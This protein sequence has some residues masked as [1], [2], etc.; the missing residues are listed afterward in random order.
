MNGISAS[1]GG[2]ERVEAEHRRCRGTSTTA[3]QGS[4]WAA[5][6][7]WPGSDGRAGSAAGPASRRRAVIRGVI[8]PPPFDQLEERALDVGLAGAPQ[9]AVRGVVG[10]QPCPRASAAAGRTV[11][12]V[13]HVAAHDA[14]PCRGRR[15][16]GR[17]ST[18]RA[19]APGRD[20]RWARRARAGR[21]RRAG[22]PP[23]DARLR[24]PPL[25]FDHRS[26][27]ACASEVHRFDAACDLVG[28]RRR[29]RRRRTGGSRRP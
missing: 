17:A 1:S 7:A 4:G 26:W 28:A 12:L 27:S 24:W 20:R 29:A 10:E 14:P 19:A 21:G 23:G 22:R 9:D 16:R 15:P 25:R 18:G 3:A 11:R 2:P 5:R 6:G 8:V 13:H